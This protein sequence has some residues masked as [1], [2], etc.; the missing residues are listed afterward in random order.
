MRVNSR[1]LINTALKKCAT[2][3]GIMKYNVLHEEEAK[4]IAK[5]FWFKLINN[6]LFYFG[7]NYFGEI[8]ANE[9]LGFLVLENCTVSFR[10]EDPFAFSIVFTG[11]QERHLFSCLNFN[12]TQC[13]VIA[14][15][16]SSYE[17]LRIQAKILEDKI[18]SLG[19]KRATYT[20]SSSSSV[21]EFKC[22]TPAT[23]STH[24]DSQR[25]RKLPTSSDDRQRHRFRLTPDY[26]MRNGDCPQILENKPSSLLSIRENNTLF[27]LI[28]LRC[29]SMA[30]AVVQVCFADPP[31]RS[32][33]NLRHCGVLCFIKDNIKHSY[34][35]RVFCLD[36]QS[37]VW[38][39]E[40]YSSFEYCSPRPHFHTFEGDDCRVGLNFANDA[41]AEFFLMAIEENM[42]IKSEKRGVASTVIAATVA[43]I[44][45]TDPSGYKR[46]SIEN[47]SANDDNHKQHKKKKITKADIGLPSDFKHLSHVGWDPNQGFALDN[48]D[49]NLLKFFAR[50]AIVPPALLQLAPS[51]KMA[52]VTIIAPPP[53]PADS[54]PPPP[55]LPPTPSLDRPFTPIRSLDVS[56]PS[57]PVAPVQPSRSALMDTVKEGQKLTSVPADAD[58]S[59]NKDLKSSVTLDSRSSLL[60]QI[61]AGKRLKPVEK[62]VNPEPVSDDVMEV[63]AGALARV[64]EERL[65]REY[66]NQENVRNGSDFHRLIIC[67]IIKFTSDRRQI[68]QNRATGKTSDDDESKTAIDWNTTT[69]GVKW[70]RNCDFPGYDIKYQFMPI[71]KCHLK[72]CSQACMALSG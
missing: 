53:S 21:R 11:N 14:L 54:P 51:S 7:L 67:Y 64:L 34:Y 47:Y 44:G 26:V 10:K 56:I 65:R 39:Q 12:Q 20:T 23:Q 36:R 41:E 5:E 72:C 32:Q 4:L 48:V 58:Q 22:P 27:K 49:P 33:W 19:G 18:A 52:P 15:R 71:E 62:D 43:A 63:M 59:M 9:P 45:E 60:V 1:E 66:L 3:E 38:E 2:I 31:S 42:R 29:N 55:P 50:V 68:Q 17:H 61:R 40:L 8:R 37:V 57:T 24:P 70:L 69:G 16:Q 25:N 30:S 6:F 28:G 13:W 35:L 46:I